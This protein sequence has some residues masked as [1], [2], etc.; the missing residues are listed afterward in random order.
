MENM[1]LRFGDGYLHY[2]MP[3]VA[4]WM[5]QVAAGRHF[6]IKILESPGNERK[7]L[8]KSV[9]TLNYIKLN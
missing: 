9:E 7:G 2:W 5:P 6:T 1:P 8:A 3:Q 4:A